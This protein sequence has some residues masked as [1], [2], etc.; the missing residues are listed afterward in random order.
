MA[1]MGVINVA[2][3]GMGLLAVGV[4]TMGITAGLMS[5]GLIQI[6]STTNPRYMAIRPNRPIRGAQ[7]RLQASHGDRYDAQKHPSAVTD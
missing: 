2:I 6:R 1:A 7:H 5:K 3:V 4:N